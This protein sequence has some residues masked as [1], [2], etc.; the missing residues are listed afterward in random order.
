MGGA[1]VDWFD[2]AYGGQAHL[3]TISYEANEELTFASE[4]LHA[5]HIINCAE[6]DERGV[7]LSASR[8][9]RYTGPGRG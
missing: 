7:L 9:V 1:S 8:Y 3:L 4:L 5:Q 6:N 2:L